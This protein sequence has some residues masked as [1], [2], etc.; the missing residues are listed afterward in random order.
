[1]RRIAAFAL[2]LAVSLTWIIPTTLPAEHVADAQTPA[3]GI[4]LTGDFKGTGAS[5]IATVSDPGDNLGIKIQLLER[6]PATATFAVTDWYASLPGAFD[7]GRM[8]WAATD[9]NFDGKTDLIALYDDGGTSV[10]LLVWL[11]TGTAFT[12]TGAA[13]WWA[14]DG[15]AWSRTKAII[16]GSFSAVGH[17]G[18]LFIYQYDN[19]DMRIHYLE[20][21][22]AKFIYTGNQGVYDSGPGQYDTARARFVVGRFT[23]TSGPDQLA[24]VY[25]YP[26]YQITIHVFDPTPNGLRPVNGWGGV[27]TSGVNTYDISKAKFAATDADGDGRTDLLGFYWYGD[28]SVRVHIFRGAQNLALVDTNGIATFA[29]F[30]MP[31]LETRVVAGDFNKDRRGDLAL[32]T[33]LIDGSSHV[34]VLQSDGTALQWSSDAWVSQAGLNDRCGSCWPLSG[35]PL[36]ATSSPNHRTLAVKIDNAPAARPHYG[37]SQADMVLELLV[38]GFITRLAGYFHSQDPGT[39]G[40]IRSVRYS[41][42]YTTPMVRG[43]IAASGASQS[44]SDL[45]NRDVAN[46]NYVIVSPQFGEGASFFRAGYDGKVAPHNLFSTGAALRQG[47]ANEGGAGPVTVPSWDFLTSAVHQPTAGGF[48]GSVA[49]TSI[50]IP[51]RSDATVRYQYDATSNTYARYQSNGASFVREVDAANG[52]AIAARNV[53][54]INTDVITTTVQ[55]DAGGAF[56]LDMRLTGTGPATMFRDG[57]RQDGTWYRGTWFDPFTFISQNGERMLLSPGQTW[58]HIVPI[59]WAIPSS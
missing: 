10:R 13:G 35:R 37:I 57:R 12:F 32:L 34:G 42:R 19:F 54:V 50:E 27:W 47:A 39:V 25:Q 48:F 23:R 33:S 51:Y 14:S 15:Y 21:D 2:S 22:G 49:A 17:N 31:W 26:D 20:S 40:A 3:A 59:D 28:G 8:K 58:I 52:V 44:T 36:T 46:G 4:P 41:D 7:L 29:P 18:L 45:I 30:S 11:S 24:S 38:E 1:M 43:V 9:A 56:S 6:D 16:A 5:Q 53:V 55:E